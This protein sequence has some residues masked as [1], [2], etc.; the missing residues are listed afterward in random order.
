MTDLKILHIFAIQNDKILSVQYNDGKADTFTQCF[1]DWEDVEY[2]R[3]YFKE[4]IDLLQKPFWKLNVMEATMR[5]MQ[6][7][8]DFRDY[9]FD[10]IK[11][12][13]DLDGAVFH[14]LH[15]DEMAFERIQ[16]KAYGT[17]N[18]SMLRLY[19]IRLGINCYLVTG[20]GIKLTEAIQDDAILAKELVKLEFVQAY[21]KELGIDD[22]TDLGYLE[23]KTK[24]V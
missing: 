10:C 14:T 23:I 7:A 18:P 8:N 5:L 1:E 22:F 16:S 3:S 13:E 6:E 12:E 15:K 20:G 19:A 11:N 2:V 17:F 4:R 24:H 9:I 21:L